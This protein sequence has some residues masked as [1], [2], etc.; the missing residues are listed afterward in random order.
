MTSPD[1]AA[2]QEL[3]QHRHELTGYFYRMLASPLGTGRR[4]TMV[5]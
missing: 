4:T 3:E 5:C 2:V 1:T